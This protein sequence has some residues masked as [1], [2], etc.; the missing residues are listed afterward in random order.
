MKLS[1]CIL[2]GNDDA[3]VRDC[4]ES[5]LAQDIDVE[6]EIIVGDDGSTDGPRALLEAL[7]RTHGD[8]LRMRLRSQPVGFGPNLAETV[9][10]CRGTYVAFIDGN[11]RWTFAQKLKA[12]V[13]HLEANPSHSFCFHTAALTDAV[14]QTL[15]RT[16]P[17]SAVPSV[18]DI[19]ALTGEDNPIT[20]GSLVARREALASLPPGLSVRNLGFRSLCALLAA[21][22]KGGFLSGTWS[23]AH[24]PDDGAPEGAEETIGLLLMLDAIA[25]QLGAQEQAV[26]RERAAQL[27]QSTA[28]EIAEGRS[29]VTAAALSSLRTLPDGR[30]S[31]EL[32]SEV[33]SRVSATPNGGSIVGA[34]A[35]SER[36]LA[37]ARANPIDSLKQLLLYRML[38]FLGRQSSLFSERRRDRFLRSAEKRD[39]ARSLSGYGVARPAPEAPQPSRSVGY[40]GGRTRD[41]FR[42]TVLVVSHDGSRTGAP[43]L[44][45]NVA[46]ELAKRYNVVFLTLRGGDMVPAFSETSVETI[47]AK[48]FHHDGASYRGMIRGICAANNF[49]FAVVNSLES[50]GVLRGLNECGVPIVSLIHEFSS[51]TRPKSAI[52]EVF[53]HSRETVFSTNVTLQNALEENGLQPD[54]RLTVLPQGKCV[55]PSEKADEASHGEEVAWLQRMMRPEGTGTDRILV[56]GGGSVQIRKGVDLFV[57]IA[58]RVREMPQGDRFRFVWIGG[59]YDPDKDFGYSVYIRDQIRRSGLTDHVKMLRETTAIETAYSLADIF[60]LPSRLDPLPN[61]AIDSLSVGLPVLCFDRTTGIAEVLLKHGLGEPCV[62]RYLDTTEMAGKVYRMGIDAALYDDV[63][64]RSRDLAAKVFDMAS[65]VARIEDLALGRAE[66]AGARAA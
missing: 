48:N 3:R 29:A 18:V 43:I 41:A 37:L 62:A 39:P 20:P 61:V 1:V 55:V 46:Q 23:E 63:A 58:N 60:L 16:I 52:M 42:L 36:Q 4:I 49:A 28:R 11:E 24:L 10:A 12:Q 21:R 19:R 53:R 38:R 34:L 32:L 51:Y 9:A 59:N 64:R 54:P 15:G 27:L 33:T 25:P 8:R 14:G 50:R 30:L 26:V 13:A 66:V 35:E 44:A 7:A 56:L 17:A 57:E 6:H 5:V 22:G 65:Y 47:V 2:T 45:L 31:V 40:A